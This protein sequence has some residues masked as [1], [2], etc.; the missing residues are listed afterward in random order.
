M[1]ELKNEEGKF[2]EIMSIDELTGRNSD[3]TTLKEGE[4]SSKLPLSQEKKSS[5]KKMKRPL[6]KC[7]I[8]NSPPQS[9]FRG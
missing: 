1:R 7:F 3:A 2:N 5:K 6:Q 9:E 4:N 8:I